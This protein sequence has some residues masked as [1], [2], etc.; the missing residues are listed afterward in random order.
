[1]TEKRTK[2][3]RQGQAITVRLS[4]LSGM[5]LC[6][7]PFE[8]KGRSTPHHPVRQDAAGT[9]T[10]QRPGD[11]ETTGLCSF[12]DDSSAVIMAHPEMALA[13][14]VMTASNST[15][16]PKTTITAPHRVIGSIIHAPVIQYS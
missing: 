9:V 5:A 12:I 10:A 8:Q 11:K 16:K 3:I 1:M 15:H 7:V 14:F 13:P 6:E 4:A 2:T